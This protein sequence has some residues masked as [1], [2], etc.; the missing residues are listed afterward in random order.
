MRKLWQEN[1]AECQCPAW[2]LSG[3]LCLWQGYEGCTAFGSK[4]NLNLSCQTG[5]VCVIDSLRF[6]SVC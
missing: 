3:L 2:W 6:D 1:K 4:K 5:G